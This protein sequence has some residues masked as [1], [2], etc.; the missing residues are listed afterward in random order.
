[1]PTTP[2]SKLSLL[3]IDDSPVKTQSV[4]I[5]LSTGDRFGFGVLGDLKRER[6]VE[7]KDPKAYCQLLPVN[8]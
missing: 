2:Y 5:L 8:R 6:N 1:M 4:A 7:R 3:T